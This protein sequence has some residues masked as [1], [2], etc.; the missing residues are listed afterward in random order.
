MLFLSTFCV[1]VLIIYFDTKIEE[2]GTLKT[3]IVIHF[4]SI[5][6]GPSVIN[7]I[8]FLQKILMIHE[9]KTPLLFF[10]ILFNYASRK[11]TDG[12]TNLVNLKK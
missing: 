2:W 7:I 4:F 11:L 5:D 9:I 8:F 10:D 6:K 3:K 1:Q 12:T